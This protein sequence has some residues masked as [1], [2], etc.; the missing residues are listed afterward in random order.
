MNRST[1]VM[2]V[3]NLTPD[4]FSD[5]GSYDGPHR[6][7]K[8]VSRMAKQGAAVIDI[9]AQST[10]PGA[11]ELG[12]QI[13]LERLLP[14]LELICQARLQ[15]NLPPDLLLSI[16]TFHAPVAERALGMGVNWIN[17]VSGGTS[18]PAMLPLVAQSGCPYVLMHRRGTSKT[19]QDFCNYSDVVCEVEQELLELTA[20]A[21]SAG[22]VRSQLWWD[23]GLG[24][25][26]TTNQNLALLKGLP[27]LLIH[28]F[29][30]LVGPSR[31]RFIG[32]IINEPR[33]KARSWGTAAVVCKAIA[34]GAAMVRV[35]DVAAMAQICAMADALWPQATNAAVS[36]KAPQKLA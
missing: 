7:L 4:S 30:L 6:A 9:G 3:L 34:A 26:K 15:G 11:L 29:P 23:P 17:D 28:G 10:R 31:K 19:M 5:G 25:A 14:T 20:R 21:L 35:H 22:I 16:D 1:K 24:F 8:A 13:E 12:P 27:R 36:D 18:D 33:A 32:E 2:G